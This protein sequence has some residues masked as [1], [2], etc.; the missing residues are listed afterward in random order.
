MRQFVC[1]LLFFCLITP[2]AMTQ[3]RIS[4]DQIEDAFLKR[5]GGD[6]TGDIVAATSCIRVA[7][8]EIET[9]YGEIALVSDGPY[10]ALRSNLDLFLDPTNNGTAGAVIVP[11]TM[12]RFPD[13][14][15]DKISFY[16]HSYRIGISP[17]DLDLTSDRNI[18]FHSDT[19]ED[20]MVIEGDA[21]DVT[22]KRNLSIG[23]PLQL[24]VVTS[25]PSG[26]TGQMLYYDH[27]SDSS[28]DG[29]YVY[30]SSGWQKL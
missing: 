25:L 23:G 9:E 4:A 30:G 21:G 1:T 17:F 28:Q 8:M 5:S 11:T 3:T 27:P 24:H 10:F 22:I 16:S 20:L 2:F 12:M 26:A 7:S 14:L 13:F 19:V 15:G 18:K 6:V 29:V